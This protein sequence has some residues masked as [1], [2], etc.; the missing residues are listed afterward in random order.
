MQYPTTEN[1]EIL[2]SLIQCAVQ[3]VFDTTLPG[4]QD[5]LVCQLRLELKDAP[6]TGV[7]ASEGLSSSTVTQFVD[8]NYDKKESV[9]EWTNRYVRGFQETDT[10]GFAP[11]VSAES[12]AHG[13]LPLSHQEV[14]R[15]AGDE[16]S[17][18]SSVHNRLK[19]VTK[20]VISAK[21]FARSA[22]VSPSPSQE[23][24]VKGSTPVQAMQYTCEAESENSIHRESARPNLERAD[25]DRSDQSQYSFHLLPTLA[26]NALQKLD[27]NGLLSRSTTSRFVKSNRFEAIMGIIVVFSVL[28]LGWESH[29]EARGYNLGAF[30]VLEVLFCIIFVCEITLRI[31]VFHWCFFTGHGCYFNMLDF[32]IVGLQLC[33]MVIERV[34]TESFGRQALRS[35]FSVLRIL[36]LIRLVR[37]ARI[38]RQIRDLRTLIFSIIVSLRSLLWTLL[39][40]ALLIYVFSVVITQLVTQTIKNKTVYV[41]PDNK[42]SLLKYYGGMDKSMFSLF[43]ALFGGQDWDV[44]VR[45]LMEDVHWTLSLVFVFYIA[46][47]SLA[48]LN[49]VTGVFVDNVLECARKD[50]ETFL[51]NNVRELFSQLEGGVHGVMTW[52]V[53]ESKLET[54]EMKAAFKAINVDL[55][56]ARGLFSLLDLDNSKEVNAQEFLA[57]CLRLR[58]PAKALDLAVLIREVKHLRERWLHSR[59]P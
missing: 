14:Q 28:C 17:S 54:E 13:L 59:H 43:E 32:G 27:F 57:G 40:L 15:S 50:K 26:H 38:L 23:D 36:K 56:E 2:K 8:D 45:P 21:R 58:G 34:L 19:G 29:S 25:S 37:I 53:F 4:F 31:Y 49:V 6:V 30:R 33:Q 10:W 39:L 47:S 11:R 16:S 1:P 18:T 42:A 9:Y 55:S 24:S 5:K 12:Q 46:F 51:I 22:K 52:E 20:A 41:V 35:I 48:M 44:L 7:K 3:D